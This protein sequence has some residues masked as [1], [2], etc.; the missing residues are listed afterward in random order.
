[1][2][3]GMALRQNHGFWR[4]EG[5][6]RLFTT[7]FL[8]SVSKLLKRVIMKTHVETWN[9]T[10]SINGSSQKKNFKKKKGCSNNI[11]QKDGIYGKRKAKTNKKKSSLIKPLCS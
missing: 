11:Y 8:M 1:M 2:E 3:V 5:I 9:R 10:F 4:P 6:S 7:L